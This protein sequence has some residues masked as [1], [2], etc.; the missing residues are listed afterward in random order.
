MKSGYKSWIKSHLEEILTA[1]LT[2]FFTAL[3]FRVGVGMLLAIIGGLAIA[4]AIRFAA[5]PKTVQWVKQHLPWL[6]DSK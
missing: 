5:V 3:M 2:A 1:I 6:D 4:Y